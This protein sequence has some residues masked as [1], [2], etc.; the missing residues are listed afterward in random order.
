MTRARRATTTRA[1]RTRGLGGACGLLA[2][3]MLGAGCGGSGGGP[4]PVA[5]TAAPVTTAAATGYVALAVA[6]DAPLVV[7]VGPGG[8]FQ[9]AVDGW[10]VDGRARDLTR[11]ASYESLDPGVA[12][13]R[14]D[15]LVEGVAPGRTQVLARVPDR[16]GGVLQ[17][18]RWVE[19][20]A[21]GAA[22]PAWT[23]LAVHPT[24]RTLDLVD[25]AAGRDQ[26][27]QV[28][29]W[30]TDAQGRAFDLTRSLGVRVLD[31]AQ[32][33]TLAAQV[34]P[35]GLLRATVDGEEVL[36][37][38]RLDDADL[39]AG[40]RLVL[41][42]GPA[43][44]PTPDELYAGGPL[45]GSSNPID[46]AVLGALR[47]RRIEPAALAAD[48][49]FLRR[50]FLDAAGRPPSAAERAAFLA[51]PAATRR[52]DEVRRLLASDDFA[53]HW[54]ARLGEW[55]LLPAAGR[56]AGF[57]AWAADQLRAG[58][59]L[60][61]VVTDLATGAG[62][63]GAV[64]EARHASAADKV[65][66]LLQAGAGMTARCARCHDHPLTGPNDAPRW[67]QDERYPLDAFFAASP[68]EA[69][70]LN[71]AGQRFDAPKQ[72]GFVLD[73]A[74]QV[75]STLRTPLAQRRAEFARLFVGSRAFQR[76][77]AHRVWATVQPALLDPD[78]FLRK[79]LDAVANPAL[80]DA[81]TD[82]FA[83]RGASL[84][85]LLEE[86]F[87]SRTYQLAS[88]AAAGLGGRADALLARAPLR[89]LDAEAVGALV[90]QVTGQPLQGADRAYVLDTFGFP[91]A[92]AA[93]HERS[94][95]IHMGQPLL[96]ANA[97]AVQG[98][99]SSRSSLT[100]AVAADLAAGTLD[101]AAA[102]ERLF[103]AVLGRGPD[104][105]ERALGLDLLAQAA[106]PREG[107]DDL[108]AGLLTTVEAVTR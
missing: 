9:L 75:Q 26:L 2:C 95:A 29:V 5:S 106:T 100:A 53:R 3:G 79:N 19:V 51:A 84:Q 83:A 97:P 15:G 41:G 70:K 105:D 71:R 33:P 16:A 12:R 56:P 46:V 57:D 28:V 82:R 18:S 94:A 13:V 81:L 98:R 38:A 14:G 25:A 8:G 39:T 40:G 49:A 43:A 73:P 6:P 63:G 69:T 60:A 4:G 61:D 52:D 104:P 108:A 35:T 66:A 48:D 90:E 59:S 88:E 23:A 86:V 87:T 96:L 65:D 78:Q 72:P 44:P 91:A 76:G 45:R 50:L 93:V 42:D 32:G 103:V 54:A 64:F 1:W 21:A 80:L 99:L 55:F 22:Q 101:A 7:E 58:R 10:L 31:P 30:A 102:V 11:D 20:V 85:G 17:E 89:R 27:Q 68:V 107:L 74:A 92:R 37:R 77:L 67:T 62:T 24:D 36:L 47:A 34:T